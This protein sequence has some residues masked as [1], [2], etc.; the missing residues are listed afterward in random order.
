MIAKAAAEQN[1]RGERPY[2][3]DR[4]LSARNVGATLVVNSTADT[5]TAGT[6]RFAL[7][8]ASDG[9]TIT[10]SLPA[11]SAIQLTGDLPTITHAITISG[12]AVT[13]DGRASYRPF[14]IDAAGRNVSISNLTVFD[15]KAIGGSG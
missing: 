13:I 14:F 1:V 7:N 10:V 4:S 9:D 11:N 3:R 6:L 2:P 8:N 12:D 15:A 5:N